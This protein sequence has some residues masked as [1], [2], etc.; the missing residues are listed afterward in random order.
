MW[1]IR[2]SVIREVTIDLPSVLVE[3]LGVG[4]EMLANHLT[5]LAE[6]GLNDPGN[7]PPPLPVLCRICERQITPWWFEKHTEL[8]LQEHRA[9]MEVQLAQE[10]LS[11]H[12]NSIVKVL[13]ALEAQNRQSRATSGEIS[14]PPP[15]P[16]YKGMPIQPSSTPSSGTPSGRN[17]PASPP[18]RSRDR[19]AGF[20]HHRARSF[21]IRRPLSRIVELVLDLCDTA[22]EIN[23][24]AIKDNRVQSASEIRKRERGPSSY[25]LMRAH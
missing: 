16:E 4:A 17:S 13:D 12:R 25:F 18:S 8:C 1:M 7:H 14:T 21:A 6:V 11:D 24:P 3:A 23:T 15:I 22:L 5:A 2:P 10:S 19:S 20:G 9:E